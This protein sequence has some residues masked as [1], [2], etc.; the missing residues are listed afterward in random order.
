[1]TPGG[2]YIVAAGLPSHW[3]TSTI[4]AS[5]DP[6]YLDVFLNDFDALSPWTV[7]RYANADE[8]DRYAEEIIRPDVEF[9]KKREEQGKKKIDYMP[10]VLP[11]GTVSAILT[12]NSLL[13]NI[14]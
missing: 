4:D 6:E 14:D 5:P 1:M 2:A 11:G 7:G 3:R 8:A 10:V 9:L 12:S 13:C